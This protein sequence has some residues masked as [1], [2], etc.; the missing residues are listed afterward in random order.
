MKNQPYFKISYRAAIGYGSGAVIA[1]LVLFFATVVGAVEPLES[2]LNDP[3]PNIVSYQGS[4]AVAG[5]SYSGTG[6]FKFAIINISSGDGV[7]NYWANDGTGSGEPTQSVTLIVNNSLFEVLL[8]DTGLS[9]MTAPLTETAF[10]DAN[11]YLR[12]W[13]S[14]QEDGPFVALEPNQRIGSVPYALRAKYA[15]TGS[16]GLPSG[17]VLFFDSSSCPA[18]WSELT[19][20]RG[21]VV[22]GMP[23]GGT[24][25][26]TR[27]T[28][29]QDQENRAHTHSVNPNPVSSS[30]TGSHD[31]TTGEPTKTG[32]TLL[33]AGSPLIDF[34]RSDHLHNVDT[35]GSHSHNVDV[36]STVSTVAGTGAVIPYI[37]LRICRKD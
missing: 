18:G 36:G 28:A 25:R 15:E 1:L 8:G 3:P 29:F 5:S 11:T 21:R 2:L 9:G 37:Q 17:A 30:S 33:D 7:S 24:L 32:A 12:V 26:G 13:F 23:D 22:V 6:F 14:Q 27:G 19:A 34:G 10:Y 16:A 20:A 4:L 31:H 35:N